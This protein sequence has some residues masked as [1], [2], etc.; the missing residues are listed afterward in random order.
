MSSPQHTSS[1]VRSRAG[2]LLGGAVALS[3]VAAASF[4]PTSAA[5]ET[6]VPAQ[7]GSFTIRGSGYGHGHGMSQWGAYGAAKKG[8]TWKKILS[9]YYPGTTLRTMPAG[10]TIKV[11]LTADSDDDL[12]V[13]PATGLKVS[14]TS[15]H[16]L[17]LPTGKEYTSWRITRSGSGYRL[18]HRT[19]TGTWKTRSTGL[20][21]STWSFSAP[22]KQLTLVL[23][24]GRTKAY[25]GSLALAKRGTGARTV[26]KVLLEDYVRAVVPAEMPT[27]WAADAVR[28]QSVAARSYA[29]RTRDFTS[30]PGYD[31]CDTTT[32]QVYGGKAAENAQGNAAVK[33]TAGSI[34]THDGQVALTQFAASNGG[35][36]SAGNLPYLVAKRDPYD[37]VVSSQAWSRTVT[38]ASIAKGWPSVGTVQ[39]LQVVGRDGTGA[40]GGRVVKIKITGSK[41]SV[42]VAG[43]TFQSRFGMRSSLYTVVAP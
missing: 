40:W 17:T 27:S 12:R 39:K 16:S 33:A 3:L 13:A 34:V 19:S 15:G 43:S 36:M 14:D 29:V 22:A 25:R 20:A 26:N 4:L 32:C 7:A 42:T 30:Y 28:A 21:T 31:I 23:P 2:R 35:A 18:S 41:G 38:A 6:A 24:G 8:L 37:G 9:F 5:A 1:P 11:W 10:T